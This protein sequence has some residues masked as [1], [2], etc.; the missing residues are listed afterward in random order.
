[1]VPFGIRASF[2]KIRAAAAG[3]AWGLIGLAAPAAAQVVH[4]GAIWADNNGVAINAHGGGILEHNG[5]YYW[6]GE[7]KIEG[8][9]GNTAQVGVHV[10]SSPNLANWTDRGI[11]LA[12]SDDSGSDIAKGSIIERPKV[13]YNARTKKFVMWFHLELKGKGYRAARNGVAV[14]DT[15]EG[16]YM[17][18]GSS[19]PDAGRWP[20]DVKEDDQIQGPSN[21]LAND[22]GLGQQARDMGLFEDD[23]GTAYLI[24]ASEENH[25]LHLSQLT[26]DYLKTTG[27]YVRVLPGIRLE[28]PAIFKKNG[29]Y[30]LIASGVT[31]WAPNAAHS[32]V[33]KS[34]WGPWTELG[35]PVRGTPE[36]VEKT[37]GAQSS[38]VLPLA[39][40]RFVFMSDRWNPKN[41]IDGRYV[42]LPLGWDKGK[43]VLS[44]SDAW[45]LWPATKRG[46]K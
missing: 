10:Y 38:F 26:D 36:D 1:M 7:H 19:R 23:D 21:Y 12:V 17:Y 18:L 41:A 6:F 8:D 45:T 40:G 39:D 37:F 44:W 16:P 9:L 5:V 14:S 11:A 33:A 31:G 13:L 4:P 30:Y 42:W 25:S 46:G 20:I 3:L 35:N 27:R 29:V 32:A 22:F 15:P 24:Y 34:L 28:A 43:P 2:G